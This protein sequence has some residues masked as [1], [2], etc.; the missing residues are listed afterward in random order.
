VLAAISLVATTLL[1]VEPNAYAHT[2][3]DDIAHVVTSPDFATDRT[4][5]LISRSRVMRSTDAGATWNEIV[6]G[7]DSPSPKRFATAPSDARIIYLSMLGAGVYRSDDK[8]LSWSPTSTPTAMRDVADLVVSPQ[9]PDHVFAAGLSSGLFRTADGGQTWAAVGSFGRITTVLFPDLT[10][11][12]VVGDSTGSVFVSDDDGT[13]WVQSSGTINGDMVTAI[14]A[15]PPSASPATVFIGTQSGKLLRSTNRGGSFAAVGSGLPAEQIT[16]IAVSR[17]YQSDKTVWTSASTSGVYRSSDAGVTFIRKSSGLT[18]DAQAGSLGEPQFGHVTV[19]TGPT[20]GQVLFTAGFDGLFTSTDGGNVWHEVQTLTDYV[21]GLDVSPDY[22]DDGTVIATTYVK[23]AYLS[24]DRGATWKGAHVGLGAVPG[25]KY[26]R[27]ERLHNVHFSPDYANDGTIFSAT[28]TNLLRSTDRGIS[29]TKIAVGTA[30]AGTLRQ[31][32]I[33]PSPAYASDRT[34]YVGTRQ[35]EIYR[36]TARGAANTWSL[37]ANIGSGIRSLVM[38]PE[39]AT[40]PVLYASTSIGIFK[41]VDAG[42]HWQRTGPSGISMLAISPNYATD[43]TVFAGTNFGVHVTRDEGQTWTKLVA[44]AL[45]TTMRVEA[46]AVSP[47]YEADQTVLVSA[48]GVGLFRSTDGGSSFA[49]VGRSLIENNLVIADFDNPTSSPIQFS[50]SYAEDRTIFAMAQQYIVKSTDGGD[51]WQALSLPPAS[52]FLQPPTIAVSPTAVRVTEGASGTTRVMHIAFDL[53]HPYHLNATVQWRTLDVPSD[54]S[55]ASSAAG[56]YVA[57]SGTLTFPPGSTRMFADVVVNGDDLDERNERV[58]VALSNATNASIG[59]FYGLGSGTIVD[60]DPAPTVVPGSASV[61]EGTSDNAV[62]ALPVSLSAVSGRTVTV[63][64]RTLDRQ[65]IGGQDFATAS[66]TLTFLPGEQI[67]TID[68]TVLADSLDESDETFLVAL[69]NATN[70]SIGGFYGLGVATILD[71]DPA[72]EV[73][74]GS[75]SVAEGNSGETVLRIPV[76]LSAASG[77]T[78]TVDWSTVDDSAI[79]GEDFATASGTLTF[80]PGE[81][82]K[83]ID[84]T[85]FGDTTVEPDEDLFVALSNP[86]NATLG[87]ASG[88][89]RIVNDDV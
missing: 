6:N 74:P 53:S 51:T 12:V 30:P 8:G 11:R 28:W 10:G 43:G 46:I 80:L 21:V 89:G 63:D 58:V 38:S 20:G 35:G 7:L 40:Q 55:V 13:T 49:E 25:N 60:D 27:I 64:W 59:G 69:S 88:S 48:T 41:S 17:N 3:H 78:V 56:D 44:A 1:I 29:W 82:T 72:P 19:A 65:A 86:T 15:A 16:A 62:L 54:P 87:S 37:L 2:P 18:T 23:G 81:Q 26:T 9:S 77:Q 67:K 42:V 45:P 4:A 66:G 14:A 33:A 50:P 5:F 57:A 22:T 83:T 79:G 75:A 31:F 73:V 32:V 61:T 71:D 36:S 85:V 70:A 84:I 34:V 76:S 24:T 39:F 52:A 68:I 47:S